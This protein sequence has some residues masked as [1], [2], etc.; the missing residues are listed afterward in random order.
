MKPEI[1][2]MLESTAAQL[3]AQRQKAIGLKI[4][5]LLFLTAGFVQAALMILPEIGSYQMMDTF[6]IAMLVFLYLALL[7]PYV[8]TPLN[9][10][11]SDELTVGINNRLKRRILGIEI[12]SY[13]CQLAY[14]PTV[15]LDEELLFKKG[16]LRKNFKGAISDDLIVGTFNGKSIKMAEFHVGGF[17]RRDFDGFVGMV[18]NMEFPGFCYHSLS[19]PSNKQVTEIPDKLR[20][21]FESHDRLQFA[22]LHEGTL[23]FGIAG[24]QKM[25]EYNF[26]KLEKNFRKFNSDL[27]VLRAS[28]SFMDAITRWEENHRMAST[29]SA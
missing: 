3:I 20:R 11:L 4:G 18:Y 10:F 14:H 13:S 2:Q 17:F 5:F 8:F 21:L 15:G 16:L 7:I 9:K 29:C 24:N 6:T 19:F 27:E 23:L 1:Q 28:L 12:Q 22:Y 25:M 26:S